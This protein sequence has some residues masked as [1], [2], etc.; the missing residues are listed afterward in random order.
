MPLLSAR[1]AGTAIDLAGAGWTFTVDPT[2][3]GESVGWS[4]PDPEWDGAKAHP[5]AGWDEVTV[6]HDFLTDPRYAYTGVAWYRRSFAVPAD[7]PV[8]QVWRLQ[9]ATV[10]QRCRVWL[11]GEFIGA[12]EGGYTP[13]EF[14][15]T[16]H[17]RPGR[18]N[19]LV[20]AVDNRVKFR[21]L[22]GARSGGTPNSAQYPWLNYGGI[23]GGVRL[24]AHAPVWIAGQKIETQLQT[25]GSAEVTVRV[26]LRNESA[27][28][29]HLT[30][31]AELIDEK[32]GR[33][34]VTL[35]G[36][37]SLAPQADGTVVLRGTVPAGAYAPW[38]LDAPRLYRSRVVMDGYAHEAVFGFRSLAMRD[39]RFLLNGRPVR[40]AGANRA[41]GHPVHGG[42]D[43]D[44][45]VDQDLS[46]MKAAGLRFARLQHT[47]PGRNLLEWADR[48][49]MLLILEV[50]MWGYI[51]PD[52]ASEELRAQF[53][54]EMRE[55]IEFSWNHPSVVGWS[56]GN[57]YE[58]WKPEGVAWTRD[59]A[60]FV[61]ALDAT[62]PVTFAALGKALRELRA[63]TPPA[64]PGGHAFDHVDFISA[65][66][67]FRVADVVPHLD[68]V[69]ARWPEKPVFITEYGLRADRVKSEQERLEHF[70]AMLALVRE[71]PWICGLSYW[72]FNDYASRYP[73]TG[74]DG[75]R[76]W[77]L[78]DEFRRP[79]ALYEHVK[80]AVARGFDGDP[81]QP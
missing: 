69:H 60:Q 42:I 80:A 76:R 19:F 5:R 35:A 78:V 38:E 47:A 54:A 77:G 46:L 30:I 57:E 2:D 61:K 33:L 31:A 67:Y 68:P 24:I 62:R 52:Q 15:V 56:L 29:R 72:S 45:L 13:F 25:D 1:A 75:Y 18:Q 64:A 20:V 23:L 63:E 9:F 22:P 11:N 21:A 70:D 37:R 73:G 14:A 43:P 53:R 17:M 79:R 41:R 3:R 7:I 71:R 6:P 59:M 50:G 58:S 81:G 4:R 32:G 28:A 16:S 44:T 48:N 26:A 49:G 27:A 40:L 10:F 8:G 51:A 74:D 12:H 55:L 36:E 66:I 39:G 34:P 65:N